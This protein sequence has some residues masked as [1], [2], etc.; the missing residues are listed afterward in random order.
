M[1]KKRFLNIGITSGD[2][3]GIGPEVS[4]KAVD[5]LNEKKIVPIVIGNKKLVK[6]YYP[7]QIDKFHYIDNCPRTFPTIHS[8]KYFYN[9]ESD[10]PLPVPGKGNINTGIE[11]L[12]YLE[13]ALNLLKN[14][15]LD[16]IVTGPV[17][18]GYIEKSGTPFTGHTEY[19]ANYFNEKNPVMMM[20]S[21][22]YRVLVAT[23]HI[24]VSEINNNINQDSLLNVIKTGHDSIKQIDGA[25]VKIA[26]TG[27]DPHCGDEGAIGNFDAEITLPAVLSARKAGINI[28]GPF[29]ADTLFIADNWKKY[30]LV[31]AQYHDQGLIPFKMLAFDK[32]VNVTLGLSITRTSVDHGTAY[33]I[34]G[35]GKAN[36]T[37]MVEAIKLAYRLEVMKNK[38]LI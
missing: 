22:K 11:S 16:A 10:F 30:N 36:F 20:F 5:S 25:D 15:A 13:H 8:E 2:P 6:K 1:R 35:K 12:N 21:Q 14:N 19:I 27:L 24:P 31:I 28:E 32:G 23:T 37:S 17:N 29:A 26:I 38:Y 18:K 33:D 4:L 3:S 7:C 9:V 34:A